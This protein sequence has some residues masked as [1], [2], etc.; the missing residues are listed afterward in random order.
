MHHGLRGD[1]CPCLYVAYLFGYFYQIKFFRL[2]R[3]IRCYNYSELDDFK[4]TSSF[5]SSSTTLCPSLS[6]AYP[7]P[8]PCQSLCSF[9]GPRLRSQKLN[10]QR[11]FS[12]NRVHMC[13]SGSVV[14]FGALCPEGCRFESH[15]SCH[16]RTLGK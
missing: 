4:V 9:A 6:I 5:S 8:L 12:N 2:M 14:G 16:L 11:Y 13:G 15:S 7:L 10:V 3:L 1:G